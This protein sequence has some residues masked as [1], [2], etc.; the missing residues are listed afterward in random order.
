MTR[1]RFRLCFRGPDMTED[2]AEAL[3]EAGC[4]DCTPGMS[5]GRPHADFSRDAQ[6]LEAAIQSAVADARRAGCETEHVEID[7]E[8]I[9]ANAA[10]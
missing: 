10:S 5:D 8:D 9:A 1:Y 7:Q 2:I 4:D 6:S 3:Y